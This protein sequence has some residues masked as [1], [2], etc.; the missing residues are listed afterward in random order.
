MN[1]RICSAYTSLA[2]AAAR[3]LRE[4]GH[5][6][7]VVPETRS[8]CLL[9]YRRDLPLAEVTQLVERIKPLLPA[10]QPR[11]EVRGADA[12]L[13]LGDTRPLSHWEVKLQSD[14]QGLSERLRG[15]LT[16][17]GFREDGTTVDDVDTCTMKYGGASA[18][19]RQVLRFLL[20][21]EGI[22]VAESK[23]WSDDDD[24]VWL[25]VKDMAIAGKPPK[26]RYPVEIHGDDYEQMFALEAQ[27]KAAGFGTVHLKSLE[28][29]ARFVVD[30]GPLHKE[31]AASDELAHLVGTFLTSVGVDTARFPL[32]R[33]SDAKGHSRIELPLGAL[34]GGRLRPYAGAFPDR[35][36]LVVR[37]DDHE[38]AQVVV[39][40]LVDLG[41]RPRLEGLPSS[42]LGF[43][44]RLGAARGFTEVVDTVR[45]VLETALAD[46]PLAAG[47][48][49]S[50]QETLD[51]ADATVLVDWPSG[52]AR[53][54]PFSEVLLAAA[55]GY[56]LSL[57]T[58]APDEVPALVE[59]LRKLPWKD[60]SIETESDARPEIQYGGAPVALVEHVRQL[61]KT[62]TGVE[63]P[64]SKDWGDGDDDI[65]IRLPRPSA[66]ALLGEDD[67]PM[68]L[69]EWLGGGDAQARPFVEVSAD[70]VRVG[71]L[72]LR[73]RPGTAALVPGPEL[74]EH[75]C[76][77]ERTADTLLHVAEGVLLREPVLLEG[78]TSVSKTSIVLYLAMLANQP[79]VRINLNG[80]TDTG[81]LIGRYVPQ[82][83]A[84]TLP[85][86]AAELFAAKDLLELESRMILERASH[87]GRALSR[88]EVQQ[89]MA[90]ERMT[91]HPWR[92][93]DGLVV[94]AMKRGWW[95]VLDEL[96][97]AEPQ[98]LERLNPVLEVV[99][100]IVLTEHDNSL[101]GPGGHPV[102]PDFRLFATMNPAEY[103]GRS[104]LSPAYRDRW[105]GYKFVVPPGEAEYLAM[106][107]YLVHG[108]HPTVK[109]AGEAWAGGRREPPMGALADVPGIDDFL[110]A[111]ARFH[112]ALEEAVGRRGGGKGQALGVRRR[113]RYVF[114]RRGLLSV[115]EYLSAMAEAGGVRAMRRALAR[116]YLGR[117][118]PGADQRVVARL[119]DAAGI[120]PGTWAPDRLDAAPPAPPERDP[121]EPEDD[122]DAFDEP[123][124]EDLL[125]DL[126]EDARTE[127]L[128]R[129]AIAE[130]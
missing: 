121:A 70:T 87:E 50:V 101:L 66:S 38:G 36:D 110:R 57:K 28:A 77:D 117:V 1:V 27:L 2:E 73:R 124:D 123:S 54:S 51:E 42:A 126:A 26:E 64:L 119:L 109:V 61:V 18:F 7:E 37:T 33:T 120:G 100:S 130:E 45:G 93:Q 96:N 67:A 20:Q 128:G 21:G 102:H 46:L 84:G 59:A 112:A 17:L 97:L 94:T 122:E 86:D 39:T 56:D 43:V 8:E 9:Q 115:M 69:S 53:R 79:V 107:R 75:Y 32:E 125:D 52:V 103:A 76:V 127:D 13:S 35:W 47:W 44:V 24:D 29:P 55:R 62:H 6:V 95:V 15:S 85:L 12:E 106:L 4:H 111:L 40:A 108:E 88:V 23:D 34:R 5:A 98:I 116:Y 92:W 65:W 129:T 80:Q 30:P 91:S 83:G 63:L 48:E 68:D 71:H 58:G 22:R 25:Y 99:P 118:T 14:S 19:A 113:E 81:E 82:D 90:N 11:D 31:L 41:F 72:T 10:V 3:L 74:F 16:A 104:A 114:S 89:I 49:L 105:R 78:E 60:V